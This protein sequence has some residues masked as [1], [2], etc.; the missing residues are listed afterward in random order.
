MATLLRL[1]GQDAVARDDP[2]AMWLPDLPDAD[3]VTL[4]GLANM[5]AGDPDDGPNERPQ[6]ALYAALLQHPTPAE[7]IVSGLSTPRSFAPGARFYE[8]STCWK[9][10]R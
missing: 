8:E 7:S 1:A 2:L 10:S 9:P 5:T 6:V 3:A 4:R